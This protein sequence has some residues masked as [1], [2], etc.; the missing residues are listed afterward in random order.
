MPV[1]IAGPVH[2]RKTGKKRGL[3]VLLF[4]RLRLFEGLDK[5]DLGDALD[6]LESFVDDAP[7]PEQPSAVIDDARRE[8]EGCFPV[9]KRHLHIAA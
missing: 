2:N 7:A 3:F 1:R 9:V 4:L 8:D 6:H 5:D